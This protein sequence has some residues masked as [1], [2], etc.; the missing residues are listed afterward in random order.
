M[1]LVMVM[2]GER[3]QMAWVPASVYSTEVMHLKSIWDW[4]V[5]LLIHISVAHGVLSVQ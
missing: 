2:M 5:V 3:D 4:A 1:P